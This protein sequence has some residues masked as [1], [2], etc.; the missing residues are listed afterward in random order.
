[1]RWFD[2]DFDYV[3]EL[4]DTWN[5]RRKKMRTAYIIIAAVLLMK[6]VQIAKGNGLAQHDASIKARFFNGN[7]NH[8]IHKGAEK[9]A[10]S[11]LQLANGPFGGF[12]H[13]GIQS[14][15][16]DPSSSVSGHLQVP[17]H[18]NSYISSRLSYSFLGV[19]SIH[20][21]GIFYFP[22]FHKRFCL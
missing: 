21:T 5:S 8:I 11:E 9:A 14:I 1:M 13:S 6:G 3:Q 22:Q 19:A 2:S 10:F 20:R 17:K 15:H 4:I 16:W 7:N 12:E 18:V